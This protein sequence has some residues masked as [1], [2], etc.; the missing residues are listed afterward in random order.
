MRERT[1]RREGKDA[2]L[3]RGIEKKREDEREKKWMNSSENNP[4]IILKN[5]LS[6]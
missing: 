5:T 1:L 6:V 4:K 2:E 3:E